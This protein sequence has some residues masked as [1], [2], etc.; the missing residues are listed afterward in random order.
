MNMTVKK[1]KNAAATTLS[2]RL[3]AQKAEG[4]F[5]LVPSSELSPK[6]FSSVPGDYNFR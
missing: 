6:N 4:S 2:F 3:D 1:P 5:N